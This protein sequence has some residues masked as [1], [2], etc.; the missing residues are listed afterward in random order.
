MAALRAHM[1]IEVDLR[2]VDQSI[3]FSFCVPMAADHIQFR[4][5]LVW[6]DVT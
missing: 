1:A 3:A 5:E 2:V 6:K 4:R